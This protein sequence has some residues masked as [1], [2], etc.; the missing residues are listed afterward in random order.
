M[1]LTPSENLTESQ[2]DN[3]LK[4]VVRD[5]LSAEAMATL[6]GGAF[7]VS[8]G[9]KFGASNF[10]LGLLAAMPTL[11]NI[12][13]LVAIYLV[14]MF[15]NR[16]AITV[17]SSLLARI[18]LLLVSVLPFLYSPSTSLNLLLT[19]L[20]FHYFFGAISGCSWTSWMKDLVPE[21]RL[22]SYFAN[23]SRKI[24]IL[25]VLL[26]LFTAFALDYVKVNNPSFEMKSYAIMFLIGGLCGLYGVYV[27]TKVP[28]PKIIQVKN[29][30]FSLFKNPF[31]NKNFK[32]L[33]IF[34]SCWAFAVNLAAPFFSVY[35]LKTLGM[36]LAYVVGFNILSQITNIGFIR[37]W[38]RYSDKYSNKT[39]LRICAPIYLLCILGWTFTTMPAQHAFTLPLLGLIYFFNGISTAGINL[40]LTN[41][42]I[43]LAP[44]EGDAIV[45]L[46][47]RG[48]LNAFFA[49]IAPVIGGYFADFFATRE[50]SWDFQWKSPEG[51]FVF[52]T[53]NIHQWDFFFLFAFLLGLFALYRLSY[54]KEKGDVKKWVIMEEIAGE[55]TK[56]IR[57]NAALSGVKSMI[58]LPFSFYSV[59][60]RKRKVALYKKNKVRLINP[61][62]YSLS[63]RRKEQKE[64]DEKDFINSLR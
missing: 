54:V 26:S 8:L 15:A 11:A 55:L 48:M 58:Y 64:S 31:K 33:L 62:V 30:L 61:P 34:N 57:T 10:Q 3:G 4:L 21:Q 36:P 32:N 5:G 27:L 29:N 63:K 28:E 22:G 38:G 12:F 18:P 40:S 20:F 41:I 7:L 37:V 23:R 19:F 1:K 35:L 17:Y 60:V 51:T 50:F 53:L 59:M 47:T 49:G 13:Q 6:T 46:T 52:H 44:K 39:I 9:L 16:R 24:Q 14:Y 2:V 42:G 45:Y 25:S 43:K 56:E